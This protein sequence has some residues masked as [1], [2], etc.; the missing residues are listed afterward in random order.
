MCEHAICAPWIGNTAKAWSAASPVQRDGGVLW[1]TCNDLHLEFVL[2][3]H[4]Q[5]LFPAHHYPLE[6][7]LLLHYLQT[8][9]SEL[10]I[11][12]TSETMPHLFTCAK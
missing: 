2:L 5:R 9:G 6:A 4:R 10:T 11:T 8:Q 12:W 7:L 3:E 1:Q